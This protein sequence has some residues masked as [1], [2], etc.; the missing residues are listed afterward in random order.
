MHH[1]YLSHGVKEFPSVH[2]D[3]ESKEKRII[4]AKQE[5]D[6][7]NFLPE[8]VFS[9]IIS[10]L[11]VKEAVRTSVLVKTWKNS[12]KYLSRLD[13]NPIS[14]SKPNVEVVSRDSQDGRTW[15]DL[16]Q[17]T[18]LYSSIIQ[19]IQNEVTHCQIIHFS[20]NISNGDLEN[21]VKELI[22]KKKVTTLSLKCSENDIADRK[23]DGI[24]FVL[25][26]GIFS[27]L[28]CLEL[29]RY[30]LLDTSPF[31]NCESLRI[32]ILSSLELNSKCI[33]E[34]CSFCKNMEK[35]SMLSCEGFSTLKISGQNLKFVELRFLDID[36]IKIFA[37]A[38][39]TLIL[40][41]IYCQWS[42]V[43]IDAP[44]VTELQVYCSIQDASQ[45]YRETYFSQE[46]LLERCTGFLSCH[47]H[48]HLLYSSQM[49]YVSAFRNL[50]VLS[51]SLDLNDIRHVILL[52]YI[53]RVCFHLKRLDITVEVRDSNKVGN[54]SYP[55]HLFWEQKGISDC[56]ACCLRVVSIHNFR[57]EVLEMGFVKY[58]ITRAPRMLR[59]T[60]KCATN[61]AVT[62]T[63][64]LL[65]LPRSSKNVSVVIDPPSAA[66]GKPPLARKRRSAWRRGKISL[67]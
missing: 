38:L 29:A 59:L 12:W 43:V 7:S 18:S 35:L 66:T 25:C 48:S 65:L 46:K 30:R 41:K 40:D 1:Y 42:S 50:E 11:P 31:Q 9:N 32:L 2:I 54:L 22:T 37:E 56:L 60:V 57:G 45:M 33:T 67:D 6:I 53:I 55:E 15:E 34:I 44:K 62:A 16:M 20:A 47:Q 61:D 8:A 27:H 36:N 49:G 14:I 17:C 64:S 3:M 58:L 19:S 4:K 52:S 39:T 51:T 13:L 63:Q 10:W 24:L 28:E 26:P 5:I 23:N 21:W